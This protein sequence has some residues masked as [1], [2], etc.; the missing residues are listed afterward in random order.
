MTGLALDPC[1]PCLS[2]LVLLLAAVPQL[3][4]PHITD[5]GCY[6]QDISALQLIVVLAAKQQKLEDFDRGVSIRQ[7]G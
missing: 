7:G 1:H 3:A 2:P 5:L 6:V 4:L